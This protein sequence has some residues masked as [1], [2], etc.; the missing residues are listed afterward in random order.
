MSQPDCR[1][2][3]QNCKSKNLA[4]KTYGKLYL[5]KF[6]C[7]YVQPQMAKHKKGLQIVENLTANEEYRTRTDHES[8]TA[9]HDPIAADARRRRGERELIEALFGF[10]IRTS[11]RGWIR[12]WLAGSVADRSNGAG[13]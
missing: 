4:P 6:Q 2:L 7:S 8:S 3:A 1:K 12:G 11:S 13:V 9:R 10:H 5:L